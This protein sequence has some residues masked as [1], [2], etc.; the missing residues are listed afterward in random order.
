[1]LLICYQL[2]VCTEEINEVIIFAILIFLFVTEYCNFF[3]I[4]IL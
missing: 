1:M 4:Q 3:N 2:L